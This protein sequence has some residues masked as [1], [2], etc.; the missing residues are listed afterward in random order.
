MKLI[1]EIGS[2]H[3]G[4][5]GNACKLIEE[6]ASCGANVV[7]F[8]THI[9]E[10]E[11]L[12]DAPSPAFFAEEP[13]MA[14]FR[15]TAFSIEQWRAIAECALK[16]RVLFMSS[17]FSFEA[18]DLLEEVGVA[19]YKIPSGEV[20]NI[21]LLEYVARMRK[22]IFLSSGMS[23]WDEL[24]SAVRI[25]RTSGPLTLMQCSSI[26]P[27]PPEHVGLNILGEMQERYQLPVGFSDHTMGFAAP[28]AA[29]A[30][31]ATVIEKHFTFSR[32]MYGSDAMN[33]M[34]PED[35]RLLAKTLKEVEIMRQHP[36]DKSDASLYRDVKRI[37][38]KSIVTAA[39]VPAGT[40]LDTSHL[41]YKKPGDGISAAQYVRVVGRKTARDLPA[42]HQLQ[43]EDL[44]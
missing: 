25:L 1:A 39:A 13:R 14:Y 42:D 16:N 4:S 23:T 20:T 36:V 7:K 30:L 44:A 43:P 31:G 27:C 38:E 22:E 29:V 35:F 3:D 41:A 15:R 9:P 5:L 37:F 26:Y 34:E 28:I 32:R 11:T 18:V 24:D 33:A 2:V 19:A 40:V 17:P 6:A 10:A 12:P 8:Q 21:P